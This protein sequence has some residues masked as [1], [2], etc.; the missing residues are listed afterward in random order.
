MLVRT[1]CEVPFLSELATTAYDFILA[2]ITL[3]YGV[4]AA[5][6]AAEKAG[7]MS[8]DTTAHSGFISE[9]SLPPDKDGTPSRSSDGPLKIKFDRAGENPDYCAPCDKAEKI[10]EAAEKHLQKVCSDASEAANEAAKARKGGGYPRY[11][12]IHEVQQRWDGEAE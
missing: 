2:E 1:L 7:M 8:E 10:R 12:G 5:E 3:F 9:G 11:V 6:L 4:E